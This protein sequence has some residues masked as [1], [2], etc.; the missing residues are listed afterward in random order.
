M[1]DCHVILASFSFPSVDS[2]ERSTLVTV[3][4]AVFD[5]HTSGLRGTQRHHSK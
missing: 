4:S 3:W 5:L 2:T 1:K